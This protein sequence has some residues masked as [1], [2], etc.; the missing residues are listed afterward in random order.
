MSDILIPLAPDLYGIANLHALS[1]TPPALADNA[2]TRTFRSIDEFF[3]WRLQTN[4]SNV[5]LL[6]FGF[7]SL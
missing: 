5:L 3:P 4:Y 7:W 2:E 1:L 6:I